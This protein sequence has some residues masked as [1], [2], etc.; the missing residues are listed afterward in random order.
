MKNTTAKK[1]PTLKDSR[2]HSNNTSQSI[3]ALERYQEKG[4]IT[5]DDAH[6][7]DEYLVKRKA[8]KDLS[9]GRVTKILWTLLSWRRFVPPF[10]QNTIIDIYKGID[11]VKNGTQKGPGDASEP[12]S[13]NFVYDTVTIVKPFYVWMIE[14]G[15]SPLKEKD[16]LA[17]KRPKRDL[18]TKTVADILTEEEIKK[19]V[20]SCE[21][22][23]DRAILMLLYDGGFRIGELGKLT[24]G[25][26]SIDSYGVVINV[27]EKTGKPRYVR[28]LA[29]TPYLAKWKDDYPFEPV[30]NNLVFVTHRKMALAYNAIYRQ[31]K[32]IAER[33][34]IQKN[35]HPHIFRH[36]RITN[37]IEKGI[38]YSVIKSMMWGSL[39]TD[40]FASY[41]H[42]SNHSI[43]NALL[44]QA[45]IKRA[46]PMEKTDA[47]A[48]RQCPKCFIINGPTQNFCGSCGMPLTETATDDQK[49][50]M[51]ELTWL[52]AS[53]TP[54]QLKALQRLS[55]QPR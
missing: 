39:T 28:L 2:F 31:I 23:R 44:E 24:W 1:A 49:Q 11:L 46:E 19:M 6:L 38:P 26:I 15:Y 40:M 37:M 29:A 18:M 54:E 48:P 20:Q 3:K 43:D 50:A 51:D 13:K 7:I 41:A 33:A 17:L 4:V 14:A 16:I 12:Y 55:V 10:R 42:L 21:S 35:V 27:D 32:R 5:Q 9:Q 45:G 36:T 52:M 34:G 25:Q 30:G 22:V 47:L 8:D 53:F